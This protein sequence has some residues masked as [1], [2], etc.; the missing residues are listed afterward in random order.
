M[1]PIDETS[2]RKSIS[3]FAKIGLSCRNDGQFFYNRVIIGAKNLK[4]VLITTKS[5]SNLQFMILN[6]KGEM[7]ESSGLLSPT[8]LNWNLTIELKEHT[9]LLRQTNINTK[10]NTKIDERASKFLS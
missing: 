3:A 9:H 10:Y 4:D 6:P 8:S 5:C 1:V 7:L 2:E